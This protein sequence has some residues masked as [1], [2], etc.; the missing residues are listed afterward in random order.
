MVDCISRI[1]FF[2]TPDFAVPT[3]AALVAAG[4]E[5]VVV[6]SQPDR[7]AGRGRHVTPPEV[8]SWACERELPVVQPRSVKDAAF[9]SRLRALDPDLAVVVA[10]GQIFPPDLLD[11]PRRGCVNVHASLLPRHRGAAPVQAALSAG[12]RV[13]GVTTMVMDE[14]LD[15][16]PMLRTVETPLS[17][18]ETSGSLAARLS[19][20]GAG[21][22]LE[23]IDAMESGAVEARPQPD[24]GATYAARIATADAR[25]A[26]KAPASRVEAH[27]RAMTPR[28]GAWTEWQGERLKVLDADMLDGRSDRSPGSLIGLVGDVLA[29]VCGDG[30]LVGIRQVVRPGRGVTSAAELV[31]GGRIDG[32]SK[33]E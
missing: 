9:L 8:A 22:L 32:T 11:L 17:G 27:I 23:T 19:H 10:F 5:P 29:V 14:G 31:R 26:W 6:V 21:L 2:G 1:A 30:R 12:D 33:V 18:R 7:P 13:T 28:P 3:L 24:D 4:R 16:G 25:I 20:L 15:T